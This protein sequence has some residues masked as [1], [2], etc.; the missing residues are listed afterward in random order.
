MGKNPDE[1][2]EDIIEDAIFEE[3]E[4]EGATSSFNQKLKD[5][6]DKLKAS[7]SEKMQAMEEMQRAKA[8]FLNGKKRVEEQLMRDK[9]RQTDNFIESLLPLCDSFTMAMSNK[10]Q[11]DTLNEQW[12]KG[13][14]GVFQQLTQLLESYQVTLIEPVGAPFDPNEHEAMG[15]EDSEGESDSVLRVIQP[16]YKRNNTVIRPAKVIITN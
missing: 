16:G 5:L 15:T 7:D 14:E 13:M 4:A 11:W 8:D 6:R 9:E 2:S 12:R 10:E 1:E 3:T